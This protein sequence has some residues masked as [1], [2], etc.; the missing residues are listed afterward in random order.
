M[1]NAR[2]KHIAILPII[3]QKMYLLNIFDEIAR[4]KLLDFAQMY[5]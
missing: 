5:K 3:Y 2:L 4:K 1:T